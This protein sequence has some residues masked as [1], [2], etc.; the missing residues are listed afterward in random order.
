[1]KVLT[2]LIISCFSFFALQ[3]QTALSD[4][5]DQ[6]D[7]AQMARNVKLFNETINA[8]IAEH[9]ANQFTLFREQRI[10]MT[11]KT[12]QLVAMQ[13][14]YGNW[15]HFVFVADPSCKKLRVSLFQEGYGDIVTDRTG[16]SNDEFVT[17]FSFMCPVTGM[18]EFTCFQK[19]E[20]KKPLAYLMLFT[21]NKTIKES[22]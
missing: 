2:L 7:S 4:E 10:Q 5:A 13:L 21:R 15:Y 6:S 18:Y 8:K 1:M 20:Q 22:E 19:G 16:K 12:N 14:E 9:T 17:E 11:D 3:A